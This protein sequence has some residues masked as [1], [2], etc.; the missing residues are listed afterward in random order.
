MGSVY[1]NSLGSSKGARNLIQVVERWEKQPRT[2][3]QTRGKSGK[4]N[5]KKAKHSDGITGVD[6]SNWTGSEI[7]PDKHGDLKRS[8]V[9]VR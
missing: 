9:T 6:R 7:A 2:T 3:A 1:R 5:L 8:H 4:R